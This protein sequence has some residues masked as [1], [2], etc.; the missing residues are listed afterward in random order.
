MNASTTEEPKANPAES[1]PTRRLFLCFTRPV[2]PLHE[3]DAVLQE[4]RRY[5]AA[6]EREGKLFAAGPVH[7]ADDERDGNGLIILRASTRD[8]AAAIA[9]EDP[10][11]RTG[12]RTYEIR[13]W[14]LNEGRFSVDVCISDGTFRLS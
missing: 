7:T 14:R 10:F 9:D 13:P 8:E 3:L 11:H 6:L 2:R 12:L 1:K 5:L 4:H